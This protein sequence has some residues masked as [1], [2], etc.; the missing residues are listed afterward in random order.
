[1][2]DEGFDVDIVVPA[3]DGDIRIGTRALGQ[4]I[5]MSG[6]GQG[7]VLRNGRL[8]TFDGKP[9]SCVIVLAETWTFCFSPASLG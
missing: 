6:I 3:G 2:L 5:L 9:M 7:G 4:E 8:Y 1:M